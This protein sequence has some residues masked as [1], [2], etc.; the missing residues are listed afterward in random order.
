M[1]TRE[2]LEQFLRESHILVIQQSHVCLRLVKELECCFK[3]HYV[4]VEWSWKVMLFRQLTRL[5]DEALDHGTL[6]FIGLL[7]RGF[8][9]EVAQLLSHFA[10]KAVFECFEFAE[11]QDK[12]LLVRVGSWSLDKVK[13]ITFLFLCDLTLGDI[14]ENSAKRVTHGSE[15]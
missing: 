1:L 11:G 13:H 8:R 7:C 3:E 10:E 6:F 12:R 4:V 5:R 2:K 9:V 14:L 15:L